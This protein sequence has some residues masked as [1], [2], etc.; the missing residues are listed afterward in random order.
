MDL[1]PENYQ[2]NASIDFS[3]LKE[4]PGQKDTANKEV[5]GTFEK[6]TRNLFEMTSALKTKAY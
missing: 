6:E 2:K 3:N 1:E 4:Q 5:T